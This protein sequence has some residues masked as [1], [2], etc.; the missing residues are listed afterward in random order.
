VPE[1]TFASFN[2]R[3]GYDTSNQPFDVVGAC[4]E[5]D[6]DVIAL[7]EVWEPHQEPGQ[8]RQAADALGYAY[9]EAPLSGSNVRVE[10]RITRRKDEIDGWWGLA[11]LSRLPLSHLR[12]VELGR[13]SGLVD[14]AHR[15]A[16][17]AEVELDGTPITVTVVHLSFVIGNALAQ[18]RRLH[19]LVE[20]GTGPQVVTGDFNLPRALVAPTFRTW[21]HAALG[22]TF[23]A[24]RPTAQL[25]HVLVRGGLSVRSS[26]VRPGL[27]SDHLPVWA[28]LGRV[29]GG[30]S[31]ARR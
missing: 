28:R 26:E 12:T 21:D 22:P 10:P 27:G 6:A 18:L 14:I 24:R 16:I 25:D 4:R 2:A 23:P 13:R 11:L 31:P 5:L 15:Q 8:A 30:P 7:Q 20:A 19:T 29:D 1:L 17:Q 3:W 9:V